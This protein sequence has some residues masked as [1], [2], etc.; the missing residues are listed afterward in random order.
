MGT[1]CLYITG[2]ISFGIKSKVGYVGVQQP[3]SPT[4]HLSCLTCCRYV[5]YLTFQLYTHHSFFTP[6]DDGEEQPVLSLSGAIFGL[7]TIAV[8]VAFSSE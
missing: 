3:C 1:G 5:A 8:L 7:G 4:C 6:D 2:G